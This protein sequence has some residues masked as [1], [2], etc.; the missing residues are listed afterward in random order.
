MKKSDIISPIVIGEMIA[1]ISIILLKY[2]PVF[3]SNLPSFIISQTKFFPI[4][5]PFLTL[6]GVFI[7][8]FIGKK[9]PIFFQFAKFV[10][11]G[12]S[13]TFVDLGILNILML[14]SGI[15][16]SIIYS[17]FKAFSFIC[18]I[19]NSYLWNKFWTF[20]K[21]ETKI[22]IREFGKF[23]TVAGIGFFINVS[24]ASLIV[25]IVGPQFGLSKEIWANVGAFI[26]ILCVFMW[27]FLGYKFIVFK[28]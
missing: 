18:S 9:I 14:V 3:N 26:A 8:S 2:S 25:N 11:V 22:G 20:E 21:K 28:K 27:N 4:I 15:Y 10:L 24:I 6:L 23:F 5:F 19:V 17:F 12:A 7:A 1:I 16:V 13:N